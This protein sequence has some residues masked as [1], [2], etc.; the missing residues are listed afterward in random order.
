MRGKKMNDLGCLESSR[1][2]TL[3]LVEVFRS[4]C[5]GLASTK[6]SRYV[7]DDPTD[8]KMRIMAQEIS[9]GDIP[10]VPSSLPSACELVT[11]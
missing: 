7:P 1:F 3:R 9:K 5:H 6:D 4:A 11:P 2:T 8:E 10:E